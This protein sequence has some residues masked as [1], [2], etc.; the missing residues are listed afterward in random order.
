MY[1]NDILDKFIFFYLKC[2][3]FLKIS[4][5]KSHI[6]KDSK[7]SYFNF[8]DFVVKHDKLSY[9]IIEKYLTPSSVLIKKARGASLAFFFI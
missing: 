4:K 5:N 3:T 7:E 6:E 1:T 2:F 9:N 8:A